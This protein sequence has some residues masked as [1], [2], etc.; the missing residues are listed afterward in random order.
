MI[1]IYS[2][3]SL[4][5]LAG[6]IFFAYQT[7][8]VDKLRQD[9]FEIRDQLF[10]DAVSGQINFDDRGY[11]VTRQLINGMLRFAH[12]LTI[13]QHFCFGLFMWG[14]PSATPKSA[15]D[16]LLSGA[17]ESGKT[18]FAK[19]SNL[20]HFRVIQHLATS[21]LF[22]L[23]VLFPLVTLILTRLGFNVV[24]VISKKIKSELVSLDRVAVAHGA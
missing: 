12:E 11:V 8:R 9:L 10:D 3:I 6:L 14:L 16:K 23:T 17:S 5:L 20:V 24:E 1:A 4:I 22:V 18:A 19:Y 21:P 13:T 2:S 15:M 7:Y